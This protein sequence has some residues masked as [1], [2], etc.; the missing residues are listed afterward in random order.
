VSKF[1]IRTPGGLLGQRVAR[2]LGGPAAPPPCD[3]GGDHDL[4]DIALTADGLNGFPSRPGL[5]QRGLHQVLR[6]SMITG[7]QECSAQQRRAAGRHER[8]KG[9][10]HAG[11]LAH[12][13]PPVHV[14]RALGR[15]E[16]LSGHQPR[17]VNS[18]L[19]TLTAVRAVGMQAPDQ[20][21]QTW[22][23]PGPS[24]RGLRRA[25]ARPF[26]AVA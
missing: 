3:V 9:G 20:R 23:S 21:E 15:S 2:I 16:R 25:E 4:A 14:T 13:T 5:A 8:L 17:C 10:N 19:A 26:P 24:G 7:E 1:D 11:L 6:S 22:D 18:R 12:G